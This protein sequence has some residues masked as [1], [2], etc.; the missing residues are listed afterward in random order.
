MTIIA[1]RRERPLCRGSGISNGPERL[2]RSLDGAMVRPYAKF[3]CG[4]GLLLSWVLSLPGPE[5]RH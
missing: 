5:R 2:L 4:R 1:F 3:I